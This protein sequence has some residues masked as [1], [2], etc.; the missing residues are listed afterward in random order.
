MP[1]TKG[2][3]PVPELFVLP[4]LFA[5][6]SAAEPDD[7]PAPAA[8]DELEEFDEVEDDESRAP[9]PIH[10]AAAIAITVIAPKI[11]SASRAPPPRVGGER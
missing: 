5:F 9:R 2:V 10:A 4:V 3:V 6:G 11:A 1:A 7:F 8:G